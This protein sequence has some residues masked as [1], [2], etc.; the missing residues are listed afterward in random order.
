MTSR[1]YFQSKE[2]RDKAVKAEKNHFTPKDIAT[3]KNRFNYVANH[4]DVDGI[5][6]ELSEYKIRVYRAGAGVFRCEFRMKSQPKP[7]GV[8]KDERSK[9]SD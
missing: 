9:K 2:R 4:W 7:K 5:P 3:F 8:K 1:R 6:G